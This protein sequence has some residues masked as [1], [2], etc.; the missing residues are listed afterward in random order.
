[1]LALTFLS[2]LVFA[3]IHIGIGWL[4]ILD[5]TP[6]SRWLSAAGGISVAYIFLHVLPELAEHRATFAEQLNT[7]EAMA[8]SI[9]YS[10]ALAGLVVFYGLE[11][12]IKPPLARHRRD[13][14]AGLPHAG[15]FWLHIG[16]FALYNAIIG[17]LLL[18]REETGLWSLAIYSTAMGLHFVTN[19]FGLRKDHKHRYDATAR[20]I[21]AGSVLG[22]WALGVVADLREVWIA[23]LFAFLAGGVVLNVL[24]EELPEERE[25][26]FWPFVGAALLYAALLFAI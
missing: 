23:L 17:Y 16:T 2:A 12:V 1:M 25:S 26:R 10:L 13:G 3:M 11:K 8:E 18:H 24:K 5:K 14:D 7:T 9:V 6:R 20:W 15:S 22:G 19:D 4:T 21:I